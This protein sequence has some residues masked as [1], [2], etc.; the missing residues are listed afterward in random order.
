MVNISIATSLATI[1]TENTKLK[2]Y[3]DL[4]MPNDDDVHIK[5]ASDK[6]SAKLKIYSKASILTG[7]SVGSF[8]KNLVSPVYFY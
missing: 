2:V 1:G 8:L 6:V 5:V 7:W 4:N 3:E